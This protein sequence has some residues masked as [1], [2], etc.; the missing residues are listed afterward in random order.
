MASARI[1]VLQL[2]VSKAGYVRERLSPAALAS[3]RIDLRMRRGAVLV[4][5]VLDEQGRPVADANVSVLCGSSSGSKRT[6][7][8]GEA[9]V[10]GLPPG[11]CTV[12]SQRGQAVV[13]VGPNVT[14]AE[15]QRASEL[16]II[17]ISP[18]E[19]GRQAIGQIV[20]RIL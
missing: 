5:Y 3:G 17:C 18:N 10:S 19:N 1:G 7:D 11:K 2:T 12:R 14:A 15:M 20:G 6:D 4:A 8:R 13:R 9:R 16:V